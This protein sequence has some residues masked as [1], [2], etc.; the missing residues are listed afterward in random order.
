[1]WMFLK[2]HQL[3]YLIYIK[4]IQI[5]NISFVKFTNPQF[6]LIF[7]SFF[8]FVKPAT[9]LTLLQLMQTTIFKSDFQINKSTLILFST[10][11][12]KL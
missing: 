1:M 4:S 10:K 2:Q 12:P 7:L 6:A 8:L 9:H 11:Y 3:I 5:K